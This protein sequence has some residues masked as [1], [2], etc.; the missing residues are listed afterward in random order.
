MR[1]RVA[2]SELLRAYC[3]E[4]RKRMPI[5]SSVS[6]QNSS[7]TLM[8]T[9]TK[10][11]LR[12]SGQ[13]TI[14]AKA[15]ETRGAISRR[16][17]YDPLSRPHAEEHRAAMRL[18]A[19]A[20]PSPDQVGGRLFETR[21]AAAP[22]DEAGRGC[23]PA[24]GVA[25]YV[26]GRSTPRAKP[27][28]AMERDSRSMR[29]FGPDAEARQGVG[30]EAVGQRHIGCVAAVRDQDTSDA[31]GIVARVERMPPAA[32]KDLHPRRKIHG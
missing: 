6:W 4:K 17:S 24:H 10:F 31:R 28:H 11:S 22:Q 14:I 12:R 26:F 15:G 25:G 18:E 9:S 13:S 7:T 32:E 29:L 19:W 16:P 20:A 21:P 27:L 5:V 23:A 3:C 1:E 8:R 30:T 2:T